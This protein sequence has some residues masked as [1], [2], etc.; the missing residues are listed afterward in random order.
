MA[1]KGRLSKLEEH[2]IN[3]NPGLT[4]E[5]L[6]KELGRPL[7]TIQKARVDTVETNAVAAEETGHVRTVDGDEAI[8]GSRGYVTMTGAEA[9][10]GDTI[11]Q[12]FGNRKTSSAIRPAKRGE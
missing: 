2:Y 4:D 3:T 9:E 10:R 1:K 12:K 6:S 7:E 8:H 11:P 5:E